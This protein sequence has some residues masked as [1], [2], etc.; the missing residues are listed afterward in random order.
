MAALKIVS[1][2][3]CTFCGCVCGD[4]E[5]T[6]EDN[7]ITKAKIAYGEIWHPHSRHRLPHG[8]RAYPAAASV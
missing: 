7:H 3:I 2:A 4:M 6:V 1:N 8:R 5:L